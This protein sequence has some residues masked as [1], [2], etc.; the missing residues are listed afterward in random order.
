M[1][2]EIINRGKKGQ[3]FCYLYGR[4]IEGKNLCP[5]GC[6][7]ATIDYYNCTIDK[8]FLFPEIYRNNKFLSVF[9][10]D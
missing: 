7:E 9:Q 8:K 6:L 10:G 5:S 1:S 3:R 4:V 2:E